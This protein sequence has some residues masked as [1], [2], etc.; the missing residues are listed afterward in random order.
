MAEHVGHLRET[1]STANHLCGHGVAKDMCAWMIF[2]NLFCALFNELSCVSAMG[3]MPDDLYLPSCLRLSSLPLTGLGTQNNAA[4]ITQNNSSLYTQDMD[5][6]LPAKSESELMA[7][8]M[9]LDASKAN[10]GAYAAQVRR[11][12][13]EV[14]TIGQGP[15]T[16]SGVSVVKLVKMNAY[17]G[18]RLA[19]V[20]TGTD[21]ILGLIAT[22][23]NLFKSW[24]APDTVE[25]AV[26]R[27]GCS[28]SKDVP[29]LN[30][31]KISGHIPAPPPG[32]NRFVD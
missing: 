1:G 29:E 11:Y 18:M 9:G 26:A 19:L 22:Q 25:S 3:V 21:I 28:T 16:E 14:L 6:S 17:G 31:E 24:V 30:P 32:Y 27:A 12:L 7:I 10:E 15:M 20:D 2:Y 5:R 23:R 13:Q 4:K 8:I